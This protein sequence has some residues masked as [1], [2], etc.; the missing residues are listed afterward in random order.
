MLLSSLR[1]QGPIATGFGGYRR[2]PPL[3]FIDRSRGIA[4]SAGRSRGGPCV[5]RDDGKYW[6]SVPLPCHRAFGITGHAGAAHFGPHRV[7]QACRRLADLARQRRAAVAVAAH[8]RQSFVDE[9]FRDQVERRIVLG[10]ETRPVLRVAAAGAAGLADVFMIG[11]DSRHAARLA[12]NDGRGQ[13]PASGV[14]LRYSLQVSLGASQTRL[15]RHF[16][17][18]RS[19]RS[20]YFSSW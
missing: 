17:R 7:D 20:G 8:S 11:G 18:S 13:P 6:Q 15:R 5:R 12:R 10:S 4:M 3:C 1:T 2:H 16:A 14:R 9:S 19:R